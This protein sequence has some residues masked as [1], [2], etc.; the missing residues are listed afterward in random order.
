MENFSINLKFISN[1]KIFKSIKLVIAWWWHWNTMATNKSS[2]RNTRVIFS[3]I[4]GPTDQ[5]TANKRP[6]NSR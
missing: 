3:G 6:T 5:Q 4:D 2:L 1:I